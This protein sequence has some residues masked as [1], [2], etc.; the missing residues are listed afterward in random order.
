MTTLKTQALATVLILS[1]G[2]L[3]GCGKA[4]PVQKGPEI[5][6]VFTRMATDEAQGVVAKTQQDREDSEIDS[7]E[8]AK[9][10]APGPE[11]NG[12]RRD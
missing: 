1:I 6:S 5:D 4:A 12:F 10:T 7:A 3:A 9:V 8:T 11:K 2:L